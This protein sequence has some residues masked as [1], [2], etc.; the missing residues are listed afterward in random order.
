[1]YTCVI[2]GAGFLVILIQILRSQNCMRKLYLIKDYSF[3]NQVFT[4]ISE[5]F[6]TK[7]TAET[8][9]MFLQP[10]VVQCWWRKPNIGHVR[11]LSFKIKQEV[12]KGDS[13]RYEY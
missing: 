13:Y 1:M 6:N 11:K 12:I 9:K 8:E 7:V 4:V 10:P 3:F 2:V 5:L